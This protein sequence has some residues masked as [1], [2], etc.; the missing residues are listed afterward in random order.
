MNSAGTKKKRRRRKKKKNRQGNDELATSV[1]GK[2]SSHNH[3][4]YD[5]NSSDGTET[6]V[7]S[8]DRKNENAKEEEFK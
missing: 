1:H 4:K 8:S 5:Y 7:N 2:N 6:G 3:F